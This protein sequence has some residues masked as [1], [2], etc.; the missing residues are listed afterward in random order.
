MK[1]IILAEDCKEGDV[2]HIKGYRPHVVLSILPPYSIGNC[3]S[4]G[5][6]TTA[7]IGE[8]RHL[9]VVTFGQKVELVMRPNDVAHAVSLLVYGT[10]LTNDYLTAEIKVWISA[11]PEYIGF[12]N[13][14][15]A[16]EWRAHTK[17]LAAWIL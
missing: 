13:Y 8:G 17:K 3:S 16:D 10:E 11:H 5:L 1:Q 15:I 2:I 4:D 7:T 12:R 9:P 14:E 6:L